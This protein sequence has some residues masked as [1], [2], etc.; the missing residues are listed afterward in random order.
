MD[1]RHPHAGQL[2]L[3]SRHGDRMAFVD[4][5][6][7][8]LAFSRAAWGMTALVLVLVGLFT[9]INEPRQ[10]GRLRIVA[11]FVASWLVS[12]VVYKAKG[13]DQLEASPASIR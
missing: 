8:F 6:D 2:E 13:Y 7:Q 4:M 3:Q 10:L 9:Y 1:Q 12:H 5:G 11:F